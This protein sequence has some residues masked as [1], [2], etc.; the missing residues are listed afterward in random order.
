MSLRNKL[1]RLAYEKP[2]L[3]D[4][5]LPLVNKT[6]FG[7]NWGRNGR[8][9]FSNIT[10]KGCQFEF[11]YEFSTLGIFSEGSGDISRVYASVVRYANQCGEE[12]LKGLG[13]NGSVNVGTR[14]AFGIHD[15][16]I[17]LMAEG[18]IRLK[19]ANP[20]MNKDNIISLDRSVF[21]R[22]GWGL[23]FFP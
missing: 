20:K 9:R 17:V 1:I 6:A 10:R 13:L 7:D 12:T 15:N 5:L 18:S 8:V 2:E 23:N 19:R 21:D 22:F 16:N 4:Q 14:L 11:S 3:R